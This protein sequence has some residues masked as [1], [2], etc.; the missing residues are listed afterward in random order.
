MSSPDKRPPL[1]CELR[2]DWWYSKARKK[3]LHAKAACATCPV[4]AA[5]ATYSIQSG[6]VHGI[7]GGLDESERR[8]LR[9]AR[10]RRQ[11]E[12]RGTAA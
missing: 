11:T 12:Q 10:N 5:C 1:A 9:N 4:Q 8:Q 2:P 7:W 6:E 3:Q